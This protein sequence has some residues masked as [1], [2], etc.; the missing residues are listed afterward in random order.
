MMNLIKEELVYGVVNNKIG[1]TLITPNDKVTLS[2]IAGYAQDMSSV[3]YPDENIQNIMKHNILRY[4]DTSS[5]VSNI[6]EVFDED[7]QDDILNWMSYEIDCGIDHSNI[8][9]QL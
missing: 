7:F 8:L 3:C 6:L 1:V 9:A 5:C 4:L 2:T